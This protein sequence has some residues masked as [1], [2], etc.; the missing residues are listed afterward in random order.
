MFPK[1]RLDKL[2]V[3][4]VPHGTMIYDLEGN[5]YHCLNRTTA[6][7]WKHC[8]GQTSEA[9]LALVIHKE[10]HLP[11]DEAIVRLAL[12]Q[13]E[14]RRL[15]EAPLD[16][17]TSARRQARRDWLKNLA[18]T[19]AALPVVMTVTAKAAAQTSSSKRNA[20]LQKQLKAAC[21]GQTSGNTVA[22]ANL[23]A[24]LG[25]T[26]DHSHCNSSGSCDCSP[27]G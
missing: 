5:K 16:P 10:L 9:Q 15:L 23:C 17:W 1:A 26:S 19:A 13:L 21:N 6:L 8:D 2:S 25:N 11:A 24:Q 7:V 3:Q 4:D 20:Q 27:P 18:I 22:C 14:R 12:E